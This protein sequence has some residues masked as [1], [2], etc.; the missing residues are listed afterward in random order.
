M[1]KGLIVLASYGGFYGGE[2]GNILAQW[3]Q[4]GVFSYMLPFLLIFA[5][6]FG[7]LSKLNLFG[8]A[9]NKSI[10]AIIAL[11]SSLMAL[12]FG[13]V[14]V[15]FQEIFPKLGVALSVVLVVLILVGL[16]GNPKDKPFM[17]T[18]MWG[19]FGIAAF[20]AISSLGVFKG[21]AT[22]ELLGF[23]PA[24][25]W[26]RYGSLVIFALLIII[27]IASSV[28]SQNSAEHKGPLARALAG[29]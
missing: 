22:G 11:A 5:L 13:V 10:N 23:I 20:V 18:L 3:E 19:S 27:I 6:I 4:M 12:Q 24:Y 28:K 15:F 7:I 29:E 17:N 8:S 16:F 21:G 2:I 1:L 9:S 26:S 25:W 14:T